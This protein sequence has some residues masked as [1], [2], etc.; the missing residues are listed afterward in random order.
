MR[1]RDNFLT[2]KKNESGCYCVEF[3]ID[4]E[5][6][7]VIVDEWFPF[8]MDSKGKEQFAFA[9]NKDDSEKGKMDE[10][11]ERER[12]ELKIP[13][14]E[15]GEI[16]VQLLEKA[17]AKICGSYEASEMGTAQEAFNYIDGTPSQ[18]FFLSEIEKND[19]HG[20]LWDKLTEAD[21]NNYPI[22]CQVDSNVRCDADVL[23]KFGLCNHH[24]YTVLKCVSVKLTKGSEDSRYLVQ[25]RNPWGKREWVGPWSDYSKCWD[26]FPYVLDQL[27]EMDDS[28]DPEYF[29]K[30]RKDG[31]NRDQR[32]EKSKDGVFWMLYKDFFTFFYAMT[33]NYTRPDFS[34]ITMAD[35]PEDE[36]WMGCRLNIPQ[37]AKHPMFIS[38][39][40][41]NK[42]FEDNEEDLGLFEQIAYGFNG[43]EGMTLAQ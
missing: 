5:P 30:V 39:F 40:Q 41:M 1:V 36:T 10:E 31:L 23:K 29:G 43:G 15:K 37:D 35:T 42:K 7:E 38:L 12:R 22:S 27:V 17:W 34:H 11:E 8:Y 24:S 25:L 16:W 28:I 2:Q 33:I 4:G 26:M 9:R 14:E 6:I 21:E 3:V 13:L 18:N 32:D 20:W 19:Q